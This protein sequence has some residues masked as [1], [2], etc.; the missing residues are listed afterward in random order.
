M[1]IRFEKRMEW[2]RIFPGKTC[3]D[4]GTSLSCRHG[5][6][7]FTAPD[8]QNGFCRSSGA[9]LIAGHRGKPFFLGRFPVVLS[10]CSTRTANPRARAAALP[11]RR[12]TLISGGRPGLNTSHGQY[13]LRQIVCRKIFHKCIKYVFTAFLNIRFNKVIEG[14]SKVDKLN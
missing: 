12:D 2:G 3:L 13:L 14:T 7:V 4:L 5:K 8:S 1:R 9:F 6:H 11:S 10:P